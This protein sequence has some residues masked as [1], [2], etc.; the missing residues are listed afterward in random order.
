MWREYGGFFLVA[1]NEHNCSEIEDMMVMDS[2]SMG[3]QDKCY[4]RGIT[5]S[6]V[7]MSIALSKRL[8][9]VVVYKIWE[10]VLLE[11]ITVKVVH[12]GH[13]CQLELD[14]Y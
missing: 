14:A 10:M 6:I 9:V 4:K 5:Y 13:A 3:N 2:D 12:L 1:F 11:D 8:N 7:S